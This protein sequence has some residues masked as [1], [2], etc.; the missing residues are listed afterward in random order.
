VNRWDDASCGFP[1]E[2]GIAF[3]KEASLHVDGNQGALVP[4]SFCLFVQGKAIIGPS[5][6][7][8][9]AV[10]RIAERRPE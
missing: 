4:H 6:E 1:A 5:V 7:N 10:E 3:F 8:F 9:N 2:Q